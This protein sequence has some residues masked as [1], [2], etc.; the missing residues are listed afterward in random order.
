MRNILY[1][2]K[3]IHSFAGRILYLNLVGMVLISLFEGI[4]IFLL[5]PLISL[6]GILDVQSEEASPISAINRIF[7][8][9]PENISLISYFS[10]IC[11]I[12]DWTCS[13]STQSNDFKW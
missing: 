7:N 1:F 3:R 9:I 13:F 11:F 10:I 8:G 2:T 6:S 12:N 5:I 4:G